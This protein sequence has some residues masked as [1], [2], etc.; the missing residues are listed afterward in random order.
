MLGMGHGIPMRPKF[1][2]IWKSKSLRSRYNALKRQL[3]TAKKEPGAFGFC[4]VVTPLY[5]S[6]NLPCL[7]I[8]VWEDDFLVGNDNILGSMRN[9]QGP[10][11]GDSANSN[12]GG[13]LALG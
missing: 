5:F 12:G 8:C 6:C 10:K 13:K 7:Q 4:Q 1:V 9:S 3:E 2:G 11:I